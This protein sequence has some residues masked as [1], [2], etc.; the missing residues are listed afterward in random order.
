MV[1]HFF[2]FE[3]GAPSAVNDNMWKLQKDGTVFL[4]IHFAAPL[5]AGSIDIII[6]AE[7]DSLLMIDCNRQTFLDY[8]V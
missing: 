4:D 1:E 7:F 2:V 6:Y 3:L 5:P 8:S